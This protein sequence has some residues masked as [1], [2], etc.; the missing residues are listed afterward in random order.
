MP[1]SSLTSVLEEE[2]SLRTRMSKLRVGHDRDINGVGEIG[3]IAF[4]GSDD[5]LP[6]VRIHAAA[7][8]EGEKRIVVRVAI[9]AVGAINR[10]ARHL[11][12]ALAENDGVGGRIGS[13]G[14][15]PLIAIHDPAVAGNHQFN[16]AAARRPGSGC[17]HKSADCVGFGGIGS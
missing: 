11:D 6:G 17:R 9:G 14:F 10:D 4:A 12:A 1:P 8:F 2:A 7:H 15:R 16:G 13:A 3:N 5:W